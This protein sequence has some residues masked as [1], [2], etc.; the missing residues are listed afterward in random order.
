MDLTYNETNEAATEWIASG[1]ARASSA[2]LKSD[3]R[4]EVEILG[5]P[6]GAYTWRVRF[7][8]GAEVG[9]QVTVQPHELATVAVS[10]P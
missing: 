9:G 5:I 6:N 8:G 4:G 2:E 10:M 7:S 1:L 3:S